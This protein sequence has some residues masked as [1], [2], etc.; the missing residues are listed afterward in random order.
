MKGWLIPLLGAVG[1]AALLFSAFPPIDAGEAAF[2]GLVPLLVVCRGLKPAVCFRWGFLSGWM[3]WA[4]SI[5]WLRH[6]TWPGMITLAAYCALYQGLFFLFYGWWFR[7]R[8]ATRIL[9][10]LFFMVMGAV[11]WVGLEYLRSTVATGFGWNPL[12]LSQHDNLCVLQ[13][14]GLVGIHGVSGLLV[15]FNLGLALTVLAYMEKKDRL[16]RPH[17]EALSALASVAVF[18]AYGMM[19]IRSAPKGDLMLEVGLVQP[20]IPQTLKWNPVTVQGILNQL[21]MLNS[22]LLAAGKPDLIIWPET[23]LPNDLRSDPDCADLVKRVVATGIP[24][25]AGSLDTQWND[26]GTRRYFNSSFLVEQGGEITQA[27]DKQHLVLFGEYVPL[28]DTLP[29][30]RTITPIGESFT[31]G[32]AATVFHFGGRDL[33]S[34]L[35]CFEDTISALARRAVAAGARMLVNQTNDAWFDPSWASRQHMAHSVARAV[36]FGVPV[37]RCGNT[38]FSCLI[39]GTGRIVDTLRDPEGRTDRAGFLLSSIS[40]P[41]ESYRPTVFMR[42]GADW[43]GRLSAA[44]TVA[45]CLVLMLSRKIRNNDSKG[46]RFSDQPPINRAP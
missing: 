6:V 39:D 4:L 9:G 41:I 7:T 15:F 45:L 34:V 16:G 5:S 29:F 2:F 42:M 43:P 33:F 38:G 8:S 32:A 11:L 21:D 23:V 36:E 22:S 24:V 17:L 13:L 14:A 18:G 19:A 40:V 27:Y 10:N 26:D 12:G 37:I 31:A 46:L 25:L 3:F 1:T 28:E 44:T 35:I 30:L 20:A